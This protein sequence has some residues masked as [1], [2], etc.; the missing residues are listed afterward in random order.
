MTP[1]FHLIPP[2]L[3]LS[4]HPHTQTTQAYYI[5]RLVRV[6]LWALHSGQPDA[7]VCLRSLNLPIK[8]KEKAQ[9]KLQTHITTYRRVTR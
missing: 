6:C 8:L 7:S 9:M 4:T 1:A 3:S 2:P 5:G